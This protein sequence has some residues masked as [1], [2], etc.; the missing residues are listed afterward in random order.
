MGW[1]PPPA[2]PRHVPETEL[3]RAR[4]AYVNDEVELEEFEEWVE[5]ALRNPGWSDLR[6]NVIDAYPTPD[7]G[8]LWIEELA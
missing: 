3:E 7:P 6:L 4:A 2:P 8:P 1:A 5:R